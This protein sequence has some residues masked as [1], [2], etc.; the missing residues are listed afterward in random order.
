M[1]A[2]PVRPVAPLTRMSV[3]R[4][5]LPYLKI[6]AYALTAFRS[7]CSFSQA[8]RG[9]VDDHFGRIRL[10]VRDFSA[11]IRQHHF[12]RNPVNK[13]NRAACEA[14]DIAP[15][16]IVKSRERPITQRENEGAVKLLQT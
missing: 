12:L 8:M 6:Q 1:A 3:P 7:I 2:P 15:V 10:K 4:I 14:F 5:D 9:R 13:N 16:F 11:P